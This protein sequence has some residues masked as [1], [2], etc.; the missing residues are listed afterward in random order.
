LTI[1]PPVA[2]GWGEKAAKT[3]AAVFAVRLEDCQEPLKA[4]IAAAAEGLVNGVRTSA[5][6][7]ILT[8]GAPG[9]YVVS[10]AWEQEGVW[11]VSLKATC[12]VANAGAIVPISGQSF[13]R[14]SIQF[15]PRAP[16][17][18]QVDTALRSR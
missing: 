15:F 17:P 10:R 6:A 18:A 7:A 13:V 5:P 12:G 14:E 11:V 8:A 9:V 16:S 1:G 4:Q 3:K 2:A